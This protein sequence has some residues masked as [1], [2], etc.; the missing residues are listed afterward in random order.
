MRLVL[1]RR[2][3]RTENADATTLNVGTSEKWY[4]K[5]SIKVDEPPYMF[6]FRF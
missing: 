5:N 3:K 6:R 2:N 1:I 4:F